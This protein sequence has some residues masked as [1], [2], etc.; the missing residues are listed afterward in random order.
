MLCIVVSSQEPILK[1]IHSQLM[2]EPLFVETVWKEGKLVA[3]LLTNL[4]FKNAP[5]EVCVRH[6]KYD[7]QQNVENQKDQSSK[8]QKGGHW[9]IIWINYL[10]SFGY[11]PNNFSLTLVAELALLTYLLTA[12]K[13]KMNKTWLVWVF[14]TQLFKFIIYLL[15]SWH[16]FT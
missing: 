4:R 7:S 13:R 8:P 12:L 16:W 15:H 5:T 11:L 10:R 14:Y 2:K 6:H 1:K 9:Q 3:C